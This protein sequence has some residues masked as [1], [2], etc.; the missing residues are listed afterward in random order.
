MDDDNG[1]FAAF[2]KLYGDYSTLDL[3]TAMVRLREQKDNAEEHAKA[4]AREYEFITKTAIPEKFA[5]DGIKNINVEGIGR[6]QLRAD[7]YASVKSGAKEQAYAWL[8]DVGS[9]DLIQPSVPPSTLKAFLKGRL[10]AGED[11]P[12]ELFNVNPF[13]QASITKA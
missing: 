7:I 13:Q 10:K 11:I 4:I 5:E 9:G 1:E 8:S 3:I 6:V 2:A 12:E